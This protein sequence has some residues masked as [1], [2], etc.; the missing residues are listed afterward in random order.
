VLCAFVLRGQTEKM[1][2]VFGVLLLCAVSATPELYPH[3]RHNFLSWRI[4]PYARKEPL[5][6]A[7]FFQRDEDYIRLLEAVGKTP[8]DSRVLLLFEKR[9]L[10]VPRR[11]EIGDPGFQEKYFKTIPENTDAFLKEIKDF[12]YLL[13]GSEEKNV[14]LQES[15]IEIRQ[16]LHALTASALAEGRLEIVLSGKSCYLLKV[17]QLTKY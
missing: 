1:R 7:G 3:I 11:H 15:G 6:F 12:D 5:R 2:K 4:L 9:G 10:Y 13:L 17:K 16:K 8:P 14:D